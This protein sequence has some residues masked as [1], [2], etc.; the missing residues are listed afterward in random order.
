M[1]IYTKVKAGLAIFLS[2][3]IAVLVYQYLESINEEVTVLIALENIEARTIIPHE[4]FGEISI[5]KKDKDLLVRDSISEIKDSNIIIAK[6]LIPKGTIISSTED[7]IIGTKTSLIQNE[8]LSENGDINI[9][10][11]IFNNRR[12]ETIRLDSQGAISNSLKRGDYVDVIFTAGEDVGDSFSK[13]VMQHIEVHDTEK[14]SNKG[15]DTAQNIS[16]ILTQQQAVDLAFAKRNGKID[17]I[18]NPTKGDSEVV[19]PT[20]FLK[21][22]N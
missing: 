7:I 21:I 1:T 15:G 8:I 13:T 12:I 20:N 22:F 16:L 17:L 4:S 10:Y 9:A 5:R 19:I 2:I 18:L 11:F 6:K 14:I 3:V